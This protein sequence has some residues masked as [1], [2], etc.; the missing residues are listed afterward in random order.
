[1]F[2]IGST[3]I[4]MYLQEYQNYVCGCVLQNFFSVSPTFSGNVVLSIE[5][6]S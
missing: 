2:R 5:S 6:S 4:T 3:G 1:M